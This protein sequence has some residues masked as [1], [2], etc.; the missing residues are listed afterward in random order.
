[1]K[2]YKYNIGDLVKVIKKSYVDYDET[3][4]REVYTQE[5]DK[6]IIGKV[7]GIKR[8]FLGKYNP[9]SSP[10]QNYFEETN[11]GPAYLEVK[12]SVLFY[13]VKQGMLNKPILVLEENIILL[14]RWMMSEN[15]PLFFTPFK[16]TEQDKK[17]LSE[18]SKAFSRDSKGRFCK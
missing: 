11:Y 9:Q 16:L 18:Y 4:E 17:N 12:G 1:M 7:S 13:E 8:K 6:P 10:G 3:G 2:Q 5:L 15:L 14:E